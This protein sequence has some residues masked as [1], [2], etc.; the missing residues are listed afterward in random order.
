MSDDLGGESLSRLYLGGGGERLA[1][2]LLLSLVFLESGW[3]VIVIRKIEMISG[4]HSDDALMLCEQNEAA[5]VHR[6]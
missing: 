4:R 6:S 5:R 1:N 3:Q 2:G